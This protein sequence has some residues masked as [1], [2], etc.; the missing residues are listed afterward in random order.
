MKLVRGCPPSLGSV[1]I[2]RPWKFENAVITSHE[3]IR[4][5]FGQGKHMIIATSSSSKSS[6]F[7]IMFSVP[8]KTQSWC[9]HIPPVWGAFSESSVTMDYL[10]RR[11]MGCFYKLFYCNVGGK[12]GLIV[13]FPASGT[14]FP[15]RT[16]ISSEY[17]TW[18]QNIIRFGIWMSNIGII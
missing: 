11:N 16:K 2:K 13:C 12:E 17:R 7:K 8:S 18:G 6:I 1:K 10:N 4:G 3:L 9:A 14:F 15:F 5:K